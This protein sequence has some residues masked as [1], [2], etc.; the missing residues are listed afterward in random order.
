MFGFGRRQEE[1]SAQVPYEVY[2]SAQEPALRRRRWL[3][4]LVAALVIVTLAL[5]GI[6]TL[7]NSIRKS[8]KPAT[9]A[10]S[11]GNN[12]PS[13]K[14]NNGSNGNA[15]QSKT[16]APAAVQQSPQ[17]NSNLPTT[18]DGAANL[19][20]SGVDNNSTVRKPE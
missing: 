14:T 8:D 2:A 12:N 19:P 11:Q 10:V 17:Q 15:G 16:P 7:R 5:F 13:A 20:V 3:L 18:G 1:Y 4:R 9:P 6:V